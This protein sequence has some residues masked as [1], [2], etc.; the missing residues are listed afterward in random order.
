MTG[1]GDKRSKVSDVFTEEVLV[2]ITLVKVLFIKLEKVSVDNG[3]EFMT[4]L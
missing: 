3:A 4:E 1:E 2:S